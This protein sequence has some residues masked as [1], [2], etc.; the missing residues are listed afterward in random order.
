MTCDCKRCGDK[1]RGAELIEHKYGRRKM[2]AKYLD[3]HFK[4]EE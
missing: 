3:K 1:L 4:E 2:T